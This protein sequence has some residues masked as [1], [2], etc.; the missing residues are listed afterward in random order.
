ML[1]EALGCFVGVYQSAAWLRE[2]QGEGGALSAAPGKGQVRAVVLGWFS[3]LSVEARAAC[4]GFEDGAWARTLAAM[5][6]RRR[7]CRRG[8]G[9]ARRGG[10][11]GWE[12]FRVLVLPE[13][14]GAFG[15]AEWREAQAVVWRRT[16]DDEGGGEYGWDASGLRSEWA[17][18]AACREVEGMVSV[19]GR[20]GEAEAEGAA[21][22]RVAGEAVADVGAFVAAMDGASRGRFLSR[23]PRAAGGA[24]G[25]KG[26][27]WAEAGWL[28]DEPYYP[29]GAWVASRLEL[30]LWQG[31]AASRRGTLPAPPPAGRTVE[32]EAWAAAMAGA[33]REAVAARLAAEALAS[34]GRAEVARGGEGEGQQ[35]RLGALLSGLAVLADA[36]LDGRA[37]EACHDLG[38]CRAAGERARKEAASEALDAFLRAKLKPTAAEAPP[39]WHSPAPAPECEL[40]EVEEEDEKRERQQEDGVR[41]ERRWAG[42][43]EGY[44]P[45]ARARG[46]GDGPRRRRGMA[47]WAT[48]VPLEDMG[49]ARER[50]AFGV[51]ARVARIL[52]DRR[53]ALVAGLL[54]AEAREKEKVRSDVQGQARPGA[55][56]ARGTGGGRTGGEVT[57]HG[58]RG[59]PDES[60][61]SRG[62]EVRSDRDDE[63]TDACGEVWASK[64]VGTEELLLVGEDD[65]RDFTPVVRRR[66]QQ[67][68]GRSVPR[69]PKGGA[70]G[71][72]AQQSLSV[73]GDE[74]EEG[75]GAR[76]TDVA[77]RRL[78]TET[79]PTVPG[80]R[81]WAPG[82]GASFREVL[83]ARGGGGRGERGEDGVGGAE[84]DPWGH[85]D[86]ANGA[87]FYGAIFGGVYFGNRSD[88]FGV[89]EEGEG[90]GDVSAGSSVSGGWADAANALLDTI[91]ETD[92][93]SGRS[94]TSEDSSSLASEST[95]DLRSPEASPLSAYGGSSPA[96]SGRRSRPTSAGHT[97]SIPAVRSL[98]G[99]AHWS[100]PRRSEDLVHHEKHMQALQRLNTAAKSSGG[101]PREGLAPLRVSLGSA[102]RRNSREAS[103][104]A[105][106]SL[107]ASPGSVEDN[108]MVHQWLE[109]I[110][111]EFLLYA[112]GTSG[113]GSRGPGTSM[114]QSGVAPAAPSPSEGKAA[115]NDVIEGEK[116][117]LTSGEDGFSAHSGPVDR[118]IGPG[119]AGG[120]GAAGKRRVARSVQGTDLPEA[121]AYTPLVVPWWGLGATDTASSSLA[122]LEERKVLS[123]CLARL[124]R[125]KARLHRAIL[126]HAERVDA[127]RQS[128][129]PARTAALVRL[130]RAICVLWPRARLRV[131]GSVSTGLSLPQSDLDV[132]IV[133]P[134]VRTHAPVMEA[135][136]LE[137]RDGIKETYAQI[138]ARYLASQKWVKPESLKQIDSTAVPIIQLAT[139]EEADGGKVMQID[140]SFE[141]PGHTGLR[142]TGWVYNMVRHDPVILP[143]ALV[144]KQF[145]RARSLDR[146]YSGGMSTY[147]LVILLV[148]YRQMQMRQ[149]EQRREMS[150][151][152]Q[153]PS[154]DDCGSVLL[155]FLHF[156]ASE[157]APRTTGVSITAVDAATGKVVGA[158]PARDPKNF[159]PLYIE[160]PLDSSNN[161]G[162]NCFR[163]FIIQRAFAEAFQT[164]SAAGDEDP[165]GPLAG[166]VR[167]DL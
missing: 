160:D 82:K 47:E 1:A 76:S 85:G 70:P 125:T 120:A 33:E 27:G 126:A 118:R 31:Y 131:F 36:A 72:C 98:S 92:T 67:S 86:D 56:G 6:R 32:V 141:G 9:E 4:L 93:R 127:I 117:S 162:K 15:R 161:V 143:V 153:A 142:T 128:Y 101:S 19:W 159:D 165:G 46:G 111:A 83:E 97:S 65:E 23:A 81:R 7:A 166:V 144:L 8:A 64:D 30:R 37:A 147:C 110:P 136:V 135:G 167:D 100:S 91:S 79:V 24:A 54:E 140:I 109:Q 132:V 133:L 63:A 114:N 138:A 145:L 28:E 123:D 49:T 14:G 84:T 152:N 52:E 42:V 87:G 3:G 13:V 112:A 163:I 16:G 157:F 73:S 149:E 74:G 89:G 90:A 102:G 26:G 21:G 18:E 115:Y 34:A 20:I 41:G 35:R 25:A 66:R 58:A 164:L 39:A 116:V 105:H 119:A 40:E 55:K 146:G 48:G 96:W 137:G 11:E 148:R 106:A 95:V 29:V 80:G 44:V 53:E 88:R 154:A 12:G 130:Q 68:K 57:T 139:Q 124:G 60:V 2:T 62:A 129:R 122:L 156:Y 51:A 38:W 5:V 103:T 134:T 43:L 17:R 158:L 10:C 155:G 71:H 50:V 59:R 151:E 99:S 108:S 22:I 107:P 104:S 61:I 75:E 150:E 69:G 77:G 113:G 94:M 78:Q 121:S 45:A